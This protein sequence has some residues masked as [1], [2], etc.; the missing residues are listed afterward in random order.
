MIVPGQR[1]EAETLFSGS[2]R[3]FRVGK[4]RIDLHQKMQSA[5]FLRDHHAGGQGAFFDGM[6]QGVP[7]P[8][9]VISHPVDVLFQIAF[10]DKA[11]EGVLLKV[12]HRAG[13]K[14]HPALKLLGQTAG[15]YHVTDPHGGGQTFGERVDIDDFLQKI[16]ALQ[17]GDRL[18]GQTELA[19]IIVLDDVAGVRAGG[20]AEKLVAAAHRRDDSRWKMMR[21]GDM[22]H[23]GAAFLQP[24]DA[25][26]LGV[27]IDKTAADLITLVNLVDFFVAGIFDG[28]HF[29]KTEKLYQKPVEVFC[30]RA[31]EDL[32][33]S[34]VHIP[35]LPEMSGDGFPQFIDAAAG[36]LGHQFR[37][38]ILHGLPHK[39]CPD[40]ERK[41]FGAGLVAGKVCVIYRRLFF[42]RRVRFPEGRR[43]QKASGKV[44]D[45]VALFRERVNVPFREQLGIGVFHRDGADAQVG[46]EASLGRKLHASGEGAVYNVIFD[47]FI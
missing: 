38:F 9:I 25:D 13:I 26:A 41:V 12:G 20:P 14:A 18:S 47:T 45:I 32:F 7:L 16:D 44:R 46:G 17:G 24:V 34:H 33:R 22:Y 21:R 40:R 39:F 10:P 11:H 30:A 37:V 19:V 28:V 27:H 5:V 4:S 23:V 15:Q 6:K 31:D 8:V 42:G 35:K 3:E 36:R 29:V 43:R 1:S 2:F